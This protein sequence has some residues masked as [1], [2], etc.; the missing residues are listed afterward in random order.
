MLFFCKCCRARHEVSWKTVGSWDHTASSCSWS[1][2]FLWGSHVEEACGILKH[3]TD[4]HKWNGLSEGKQMIHN[5]DTVTTRKA[6]ACV[7]IPFSPTYVD[8]IIFALRLQVPD[9]NLYLSPPHPAS[10][11]WSCSCRA[12][13]PWKKSPTAGPRS[14]RRHYVLYKGLITTAE[15][16]IGKGTAPF[17]TK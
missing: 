1:W 10:D 16:S 8:K 15:G 17:L 7:W 9:R 5:H 11:G 13:F 4:R 12:S 6:S 14:S 3:I 2:R